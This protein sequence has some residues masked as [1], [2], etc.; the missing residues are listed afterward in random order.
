M[1]NKCQM[2]P[3][4]GFHDRAWKSVWYAF[5]RWS[6]GTRKKEESRAKAQRRKVFPAIFGLNQSNYLHL[7]HLVRPETTKAF[8]HFLSLRLGAFA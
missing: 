1:K 3:L 4:S 7:Q 2:R 8:L 5:P 6:V